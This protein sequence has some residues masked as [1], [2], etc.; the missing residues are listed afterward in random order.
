MSSPM[1]AVLTVPLIILTRSDGGSILRQPHRSG[2][3]PQRQ[4]HQRQDQL[5][6]A[7]PS[8]LKPG[9]RLGLSN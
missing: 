7:Q 8:R 1:R 4:G 6:H 2:H 9:R 3:H 5:L